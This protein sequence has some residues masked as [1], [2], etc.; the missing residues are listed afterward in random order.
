[1]PHCTRPCCSSSLCSLYCKRPVKS[2]SIINEQLPQQIIM[3]RCIESHQCS[4]VGYQKPRYFLP[5]CLN[6]NCTIC[7]IPY[8][9]CLILLHGAEIL[10]NLR[11]DNTVKAFQVSESHLFEQC[12]NPI[13]KQWLSFSKNTQN[14]FKIRI[15]FHGLVEIL[16]VTNLS[17]F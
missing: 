7:F 13:R 16:F 2:I 9:V 5:H 15:T 4:A 12:N 6:C 17:Q 8:K 10:T 14:P 3:H 11:I 1:M